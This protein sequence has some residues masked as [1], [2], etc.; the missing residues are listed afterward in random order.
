MGGGWLEVQ[1][2]LF[3][4]HG[5]D[6][7]R[8]QAAWRFG[9]TDEPVVDVERYVGRTRDNDVL[10]AL[11]IDALLDQALRV[12]PVHVSEAASGVGVGGGGGGVRWGG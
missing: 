9:V 1:S 2:S 8:V 12:G 7:E 10:V 3:V 4:E 6:E 11:G 5:H